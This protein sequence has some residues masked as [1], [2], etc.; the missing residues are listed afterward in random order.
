[1]VKFSSSLDQ[2]LKKAK[3]LKI[4]PIDF[5][6]IIEEEKEAYENWWKNE[7][8]RID[9]I[10]CPLCKSKE[11]QNIKKTNSNGIIGPG[12]S[13]WVTEEYLVCGKCGVM[14]KDLNIP[15]KYPSHPFSS[16]RN[17]FH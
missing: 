10:E 12:H 14:Y 4:E 6:K 1:M 9:N 7:N 8:A 16:R 13:S 2:L 11:K 15:E 5:E 3:P 17:Y